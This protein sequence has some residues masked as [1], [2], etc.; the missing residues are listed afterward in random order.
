MSAIAGGTISFH[1]S[2]VPLATSSWCEG[3]C[4]PPG[5]PRCCA[6]IRPILDLF[7]LFAGLNV[8]GYRRIIGKIGTTLDPV[9]LTLTV[10][11][12]PETGNCGLWTPT[13]CR[14]PPEAK[15][16]PCRYYVCRTELFQNNPDATAALDKFNDFWMALSEHEAKHLH[17]QKHARGHFRNLLRRKPEIQPLTALLDTLEYLRGDYTEYLVRRQEYVRELLG[18]ERETIVVRL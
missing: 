9:H 16:D 2:T 4:Q 6:G 12:A 10:E 15:P 14:L 1:F 11:L 18:A 5:K 8:P 13:G 17:L 7:R 3:D